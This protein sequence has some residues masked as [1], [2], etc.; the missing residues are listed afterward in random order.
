VSRGVRWRADRQ[1]GFCGA[2]FTGNYPVE[3][4]RDTTP[5]QLHLFLTNEDR[6]KAERR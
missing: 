5:A 1:A 3:I 4:R 6:L 2:C